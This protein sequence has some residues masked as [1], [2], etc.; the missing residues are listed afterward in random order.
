LKKAVYAASQF[1]NNSYI[2][3]EEIFEIMR[4]KKIAQ[5]DIEKFHFT[6]GS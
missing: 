6:E 1:S 5:I 4:P 3:A 2:G